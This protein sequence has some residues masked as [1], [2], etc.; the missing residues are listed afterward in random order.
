MLEQKLKELQAKRNPAAVEPKPIDVE[1][2]YVAPQN[3]V[4]EPEVEAIKQKFSTNPE[5]QSMTIKTSEPMFD[6]KEVQR[7][8]AEMAPQA[9]DTDLLMGLIPLATSLIAGGTQGE[10]VEVAGKYYGD[11]V[12]DNK[13]RQQTLED[14]L[15]EIQK[16]RAI[17]ASKGKSGLSFEE[18]AELE[19]IKA[20]LKGTDGKDARFEKS[21]K[22]KKELADRGLII[23]TRE[24]LKTYEP[25][26][27]SQVRYQAT[28]DAINVLNQKN[29]IGDA[30]VQILFAKGIF[31][32]VGNLTAQEQAKFIGSPELSR[33][34]DRMLTKYKTGLLG[35]KDRDD[36]LKLAKHMRERA[37]QDARNSA[38]A[39]TKG[40]Q[41]LGV[42]PS[43]V[44]EPLLESSDVEPVF[45][46]SSKPKTVQQN[47]VTY[48][49][50]ETTGEYE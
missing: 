50:N 3:K 30:G 20:G 32:E 45:S 19:R 7:Q 23:K 1:V 48:T 12:S 40:L 8:A 33:V 18:R 4:P 29:P 17:A 35:E 42:D 24:Q 31:G 27:K 25:F 15:M 2:P 39:Y 28:N 49:L 34:F 46:Q 37:K 11:L 21:Q 43:P 10:G 26:K 41:A 14:K 16:S 44:I 22:F 38:G 47:G 13:K 9:S 36:L 6:Y 5:V